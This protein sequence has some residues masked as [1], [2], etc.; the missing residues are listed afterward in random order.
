[1]TDIIADLNSLVI[2]FHAMK[3][4]AL[5]EW[6]IFGHERGTRAAVQSVCANFSKGRGSKL[7]ETE[8]Y[9]VALSLW[10]AVDCGRSGEQAITAASA[11]L[12]ELAEFEA[13]A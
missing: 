12:R 11:R 5:H 6:K 10:N 8:H 1:M 9:G 2:L 13:A 4:A 7:A 3:K